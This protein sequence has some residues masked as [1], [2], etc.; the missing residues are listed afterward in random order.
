MF[1]ATLGS[2]FNSEQITSSD[3]VA[4]DN[5]GNSVAASGNTLVVGATNAAGG[6]TSH[7]GTA[8]VYAT[9]AALAVSTSQATGMYGAGTKIPITVAF[10][11]AVTVTGIPLLAL[12][13][14]G[15]AVAI[16]TGGSGTNT[17]TFT[18]TVG[19]GQ[20]NP[21][22]DYLSTTASDSTAGR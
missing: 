17:L 21:D 1:T 2:S 10:T 22:L 13:T 12:N 14:G 4:G 16:Y 7:L 5:F 20:Y 15:G 18:Y 8:Y 9:G 11:D 6:A 3:G 19:P